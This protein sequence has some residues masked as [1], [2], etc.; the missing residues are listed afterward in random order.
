MDHKKESVWEEGYNDESIA[1]AMV[2]GTPLCHIY[3]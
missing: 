1:L 2:T 3:F